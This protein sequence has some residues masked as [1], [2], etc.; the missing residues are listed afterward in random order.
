MGIAHRTI[1]IPYVDKSKTWEHSKPL[2]ESIQRRGDWIQVKRRAKNLTP[3]HLAAKMGIARAFVLA[4]ESNQCQ[5]DEQQW[6]VL[7][8]KLS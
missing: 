7:K 5:P 8:Q 3:Y 6:R 2:P 1:R 4:W